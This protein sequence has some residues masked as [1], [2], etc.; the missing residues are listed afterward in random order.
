MSDKTVDM[1]SSIS[2]RVTLDGEEG[3]FICEEA[4]TF[5]QFICEGRSPVYI[6]EQLELLFNIK[7]EPDVFVSDNLS[8]YYGC[9]ECAK[10][11]A[12][13]VQQTPTKDEDD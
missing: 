5:F 9:P 1:K 7:G 3:L 4:V 8:A 11:V 12:S 13:E 6:T 2:R 10:Y